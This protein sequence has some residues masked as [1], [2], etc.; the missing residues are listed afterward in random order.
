MASIRNSFPATSNAAGPREQRL[1]GTQLQLLSPGLRYGIGRDEQFVLR[2][3]AILHRN[4]R[5]AKDHGRQR[6]R[7]KA[8]RVQPNLSRVRLN[9]PGAVAS[10]GTRWCRRRRVAG[11]S[12]SVGPGRMDF[13]CSDR[14]WLIPPSPRPTA[15]AAPEPWHPPESRRNTAAAG[16]RRDDFTLRP[17]RGLGVLDDLCAGAFHRARQ[18]YQSRGVRHLH[19]VVG[20][21]KNVEREDQLA[22]VSDE[23]DRGGID[24]RPRAWQ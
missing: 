23:I 16:C 11:P 9:L 12:R 13:V 1:S 22:G 19:L 17:G 2:Q 3:L 18:R 8:R 4:T 10:A 21:P 15:G 24:G 20:Q 6:K 14:P 7:E 5:F